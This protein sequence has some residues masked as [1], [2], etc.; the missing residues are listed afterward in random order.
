MSLNRCL[1]TLQRFKSHHC[2][3]YYF[4]TSVALANDIIQIFILPGL[5]TI[6]AARENVK[7]KQIIC[8]E[9]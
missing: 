7:Q 8:E 3:C 9:I 2:P 1:C 6:E 5:K 4:N